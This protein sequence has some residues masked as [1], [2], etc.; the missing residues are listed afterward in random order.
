[1]SIT[2]YRGSLQRGCTPST[3]SG[4]RGPA[5]ASSQVRL[6]LRMRMGMYYYR[7]SNFL[8]F[9]PSPRDPH[10]APP[11]NAGPR[12]AGQLEKSGDWRLGH[13]PLSASIGRALGGHPGP[14][15]P[16]LDPP[17]RPPPGPSL[18]SQAGAAPD[19]L[20]CQS[21]SRRRG[22]ER[23][24]MRC[25]Q[26]ESQPC[27]VGSNSR[28]GEEGRHGGEAD[29]LPTCHTFQPQSPE[30]GANIIHPTPVLVVV[31]PGAYSTLSVLAL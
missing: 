17:K 23:L 29:G 8:F 11:A 10:R 30:Q 20:I 28:L 27:V 22:P 24:T 9:F 3:P 18:R 25:L 16:R 15:S 1:M 19:A 13:F 12:I 4:R 7:A 6:R 5:A 31:C 14:F 26:W 2:S 21:Q